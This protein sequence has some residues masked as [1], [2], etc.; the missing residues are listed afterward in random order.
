VGQYENVKHPDAS[1]IEDTHTGWRMRPQT[2]FP[3]TNRDWST[4]VIANNSG[5]RNVRDFSESDQGRIIALVGDSFTFGSGVNT[6]E[7][8][9]A[10]LETTTN[11]A[12][13]NFG[14]PG[15]GIDQ[16]WLSARHQALPLKPSFVV[17]A[18]IEDDFRR[19]LVA[20][21]PGEGF[22]KPVFKV[23]EGRLVRKTAEDAPG[24][25]SR[26]VYGRSRLMAAA[27]R[28]SVTLGWRYGVGEWWTVNRAVF[29][30]LGEDCRAAGVKLI[31]LYI[32]DKS[33]RPI[34]AVQSYMQQT[35]AEFLD[36]SQTIQPKGIFFARDGHMNASGH[37]FIAESLVRRFPYLRAG[38]KSQVQAA[39]P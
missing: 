32:P 2:R 17:M 15:F 4:T 22:N 29:D 28:A 25:F 6:D 21:R 8:Y 35:G 13:Y 1:F 30:A 27:D 18:F 34:P 7:T 20:Y 19:S 26:I 33:W 24:A 23:V 10:V 31:F 3:W 9:G 5:F 39:A 12:V 37:R 14:M 11:N 38:V 36:L 16:M